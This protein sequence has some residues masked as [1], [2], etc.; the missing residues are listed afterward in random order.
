[1]P[2]IVPPTTP[3]VVAMMPNLP[4]AMLVVCEP[5]PKKSRG[6]LNSLGFAVARPPALNHRAPITLLLQVTGAS[7]PGS[8]VPSHLASMTAWS[9]RGVGSGPKLGF[10][11]QKPESST[12]MMTP[13]PARRGSPNCLRQAPLRP[14]R[15]TK[16]GVVNVCE[17]TRRFFHTLT[18]PGVLRSFC[19]STAVS[20]A[21]NP[22]KTVL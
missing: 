21:A 6:E 15:P 8:Q 5:W 4:A 22:L 11:G 17:Y 18:T 2:E 10:S 9:G 7:T 16:A 3:L 14:S 12:P 1:M 19:A 13:S 20:C